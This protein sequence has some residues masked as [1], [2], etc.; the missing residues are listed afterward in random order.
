MNPIVT[1]IVTGGGG[2]GYNQ[3]C[4]NAARRK[5][6]LPLQ[7]PQA[8]H[9]TQGGKQPS[10]LKHKPKST[11]AKGRARIPLTH[12]FEPQTKGGR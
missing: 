12:T 9:E 3:L 5:G 11:E 7:I 8:L 2:C 1:Q 10:F 4:K 6:P